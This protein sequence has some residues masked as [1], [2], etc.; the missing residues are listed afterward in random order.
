MH[1]GSKQFRILS[2]EELRALSPKQRADYIGQLAV[3]S[4]NENAT[5]HDGIVTSHPASS[6]FDRAKARERGMTASIGVITALWLVIYVAH[7]YLSRSLG[8]ELA[9][10]LS[11]AAGVL[12]AGSM[13]PVQNAYANWEARRFCKKDGHVLAHHVAQDGRSF[14]LC[15]RCYAVL[16]S[17]RTEHDVR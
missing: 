10:W 8:A 6:I 7:V 16:L 14:V 1:S 4:L 13:F 15:T 2:I 5:K 17:E 3:R 11:L 9:G 12:A